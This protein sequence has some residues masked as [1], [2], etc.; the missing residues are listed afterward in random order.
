MREYLH[1]VVAEGTGKTARPAGYAIGG[2]T[3]TAE[4]V[5]RDHQH[6]VVSFIGFAP[7]DD[8]QVVIYVVVNEPNA[9]G[10]AQA[11]STF[12]TKI[13]RDV[14]TEVLPYM[15]VPITEEMTIAEQEELDNLL[16]GAVQNPEEQ[17]NQGDNPDENNSEGES[18]ENEGAINNSP[19]YGVD[20][21]TGELVDLVTGEPAEMDYGAGEETDNPEGEDQKPKE[22]QKNEEVKQ[23]N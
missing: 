20:P 17:E 7:V 19:I 10:Q 22:E 6:Y 5:P 23:E 14:L 18:G 8:P 4:K 1:A 3:G 13:V 11:H 16:G 15:H 12:A 9:I 21:E 2:K